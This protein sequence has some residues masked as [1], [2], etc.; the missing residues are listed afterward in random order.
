MANPIEDREAMKWLERAKI[1]RPNEALTLLVDYLTDALNNRRFQPDDLSVRRAT[2][3][4]P[5]NPFVLNFSA[6]GVSLFR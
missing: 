5:N 3:L 4:A 1:L 6:W 2:A